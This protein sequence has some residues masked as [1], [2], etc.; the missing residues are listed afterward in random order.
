MA[1]KVGDLGIFVCNRAV[2]SYMGILFPVSVVRVAFHWAVSV[3]G[4]KWKCLVSDEN[5]RWYI[6]GT[7]G[8][9]VSKSTDES[10]FTT[11]LTLIAY[12]SK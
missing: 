3:L 8:Q 10:L 1:F 11:M 7:P 12:I 9:N 6:S 2:V 5:M 4:E